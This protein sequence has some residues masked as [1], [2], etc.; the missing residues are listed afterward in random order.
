MN[1][2]KMS[3]EKGNFYTGREI[4]EKFGSDATRFAL[5]E[6]GDSLDDANFTFKSADDIILK[7]NSFENWLK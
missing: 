6:S 3:K 4:I 2:E 5:A 7:L 1:G